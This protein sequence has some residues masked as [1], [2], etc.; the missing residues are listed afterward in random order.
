MKKI[1]WKTKK[2]FLKSIGM[3]EWWISQKREEYF[4]ERRRKDN[5]KEIE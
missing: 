5:R 1:K 2:A 4:L 3:P